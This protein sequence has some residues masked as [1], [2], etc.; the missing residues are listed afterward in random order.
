MRQAYQEQLSTIGDDLVAMTRL[1]GS[2][3][4]RAWMK[5]RWQWGCGRR[6]NKGA[7]TPRLPPLPDGPRHSA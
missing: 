2:A 4:N 7:P 5:E 3:M 6:L 1:V